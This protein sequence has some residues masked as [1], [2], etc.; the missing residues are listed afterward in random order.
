MCFVRERSVV[1]SSSMW[2]S[3]SVSE[4][5]ARSTAKTLLDCSHAF[6]IQRVCL[7]P[8]ID[9]KPVIKK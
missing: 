9:E 5:P 1:T 3:Q 2:F 8:R 7:V 6:A 4:S